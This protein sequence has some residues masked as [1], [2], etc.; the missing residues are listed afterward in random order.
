[1]FTV[2]DKIENTMQRI[3]RMREF[4]R[5][6]ENR[7]QRVFHGEDD[8]TAESIRYCDVKILSWQA[9]IVSLKE[10]LLP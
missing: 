8:I 4:R 10:R 7:G 6:L 9:E 3:E 5:K 2:K 1:M